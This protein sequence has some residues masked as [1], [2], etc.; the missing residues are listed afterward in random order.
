MV[1]AEDRAGQYLWHL[2]AF[3]LTYAARRLGEIAETIPAIDNANKWGF[4]HQLGP[5]EIWDALGVADTIPRMEADGYAVA[6]WVKDMIASGHP[7]FYQRDE[8]GR[9]AGVYDKGAYV[10]LDCDPRAVKIADRRAAG[11][12]VEGLAGA[13]IIDMGDGAGLLEFHTKANALDDDIIKMGWRALERLNSDF[14][15]L[16]IGSEGEHSA[17]ERIFS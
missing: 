10:R 14:D 3:Y 4:N 15:A 2:H 17:P 7:T 1:N 12:R 13:S 8:Q 6:L 11:K 9:I 16:V 5:F